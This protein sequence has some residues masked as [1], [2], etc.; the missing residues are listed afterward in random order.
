MPLLWVLRDVLN[1]KG[2]KFGC[3]IGQ[4]GACTVHLDGKPVRA[5]PDAGV[6]RRRTRRSPRIEGLSAD[7]T[8]PVQ[9]GV[10]GDRRAAVRLLPGRPDHVGRGA[11]RAERR[12]RPTRTSTRAM[13]GNLCRCGTYL[14]I[15]AGHSQGRG[16]R[17]AAARTAARSRRGG[18]KEAM[19]TETRID[20]TRRSFLRVTR[21]RRRRPAARHRTSSRRRRC[22]RRRRGAAADFD[23]ERVHHDHARRHR[24]HH[25]QEPGDRPGHQDHRCRCSS[26]RSS[27]STGRTSSI[28]QADLDQAKY[29]PQ[30]A[31]GSTATPTNWD[32]L[33]QVGAAGRQMLVAAAAQ[34]WNVPAAECTT[35]SRPRARTRRRTARSATASSPPKAA[36]LTPPDLDDGQA[37]GS[38]GLQDHRQA[39]APASTTARIVTGKPIFGID[40]TLPGMLC[41]VFEKCPVFGG[42]VVSA[43]LDEIKALPGVRHAFVVE[44]AHRPARPAAAASPSSPTPGGRRRRARQKLQVDVGRRP[45]RRAEQRGLRATRRRS[46]STQ[47]PA[48]HAAHRR[49]R[50]RGVRRRGARSSRRAYAYPF[51]SHAP[52]EPQNCTAHFKDGKLEIWAPSQ[53]PQQRPRSSCAQ[54]SASRENDITHPPAARRRRLR[55]AADE[56]LHGRG[57]AGSRK[58]DRRAGQAAVDAR[59]RHASR[60]LSARRLPLPQG[61]RRR[62]RQAGRVA[63][64]LRHATATGEH[65][66]AHVGATSPATSSR[67]GF[68]P[69]FALRRIDDAARRADRRAA[70]AAQ[71]RVLVRVPVVHRRARASRPARIRCSSGS[72]C[73]TRRVMPAAGAGRRRLRRRAHARRARSWSRE[74]SGWGKRQLPKGTGMGVAF[75]FSHRGYFAEVAE[76]SVDAEQARQGQQGVGGR[77]HRQPDHQPEQR[78]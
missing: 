16:D 55:P 23:A 19:S 32:P 31:G 72:I 8:H 67:R 35:A 63:Q 61:R 48:I 56:R 69:N 45:D 20:S 76:V 51:I 24:H 25:R 73:S 22:S 64:S 27:T 13:N 4:C 28:E 34:T 42:K 17:D 43:N 77:R 40:F 54:R 30:I 2:T 75:Q 7:G 66:F 68:V 14:R 5:V 60:L 29:G 44:G 65:G 18:S 21:P 38:E 52:L 74:K 50:R 36:T 47:T 71:Q 6:G 11:A 37:E 3:G 49:R 59:R 1:L 53:T 12:S 46:S 41:A 70:R 10:A 33:R 78:R 57:R 26:P 15:R 62:Q 58:A 9:R 39:D